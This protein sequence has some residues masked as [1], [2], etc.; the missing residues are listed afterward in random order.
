MSKQN[1]GNNGGGA[2]DLVQIGRVIK[3]HGV[4][5][6]V[7]VEYE[8]A[9]VGIRDAF[10]LFAVQGRAN[11]RGSHD[12]VV[13]KGRTV[14]GAV[15]G[16]DIADRGQGVPADPTAGVVV[17]DAQARGRIGGQGALRNAG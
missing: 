14:N 7:V 6:E 8:Y 5:G 16:F 4:R 9:A 1:S 15:V 11:D 10:E 17:F 3:P 2:A 12:A 13:A